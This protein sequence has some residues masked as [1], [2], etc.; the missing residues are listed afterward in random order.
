M[1]KTLVMLRSDPSYCVT[2]PRS[3]VE[4]GRRL[5]GRRPPL[6][7]S[8]LGLSDGPYLTCYLFFF[9]A[10]QPRS[11]RASKASFWVS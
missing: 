5:V 1:I 3:T 8:S 2:G 4:R 7:F 10:V 6:L 9:F 11:L